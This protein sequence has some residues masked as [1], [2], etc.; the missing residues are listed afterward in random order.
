MKMNANV[1]NPNTLCRSQ[2]NRF[3]LVVPFHQHAAA[4]APNA[5]PPD[6]QPG[7]AHDREDDGAV[8]VPIAALAVQQQVVVKPRH[9]LEEPGGARLGVTEILAGIRVEQTMKF[10]FRRRRATPLPVSYDCR[11]PSCTVEISSAGYARFA[12]TFNSSSVSRSISR[13]VRLSFP[14]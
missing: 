1:Q 7:E 4:Q 8:S 3:Q 11:R 10:C 12:A 2:L 6:H 14:A 9:L 5:G 13:A